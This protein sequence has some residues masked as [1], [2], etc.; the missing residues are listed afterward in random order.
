MISILGGLGAI[1]PIFQCWEIASFP[2]SMPVHLA[3]SDKG[4]NGGLQRKL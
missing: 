1:I 4:L 3:G 2:D